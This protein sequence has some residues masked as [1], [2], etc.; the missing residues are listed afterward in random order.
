MASTL[1]RYQTPAIPI[2]VPQYQYQYQNFAE[3]NTNTNT[4]TGLWLK[5]NTNTNTNTGLWLEANTNTNTNT[6]IWLEVNTNTNTN[7]GQNSNTSIPIPILSIDFTKEHL[8]IYA[9]FIKYGK[10]SQIKSLFVKLDAHK[11]PFHKNFV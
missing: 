5:A 7:T 6:L 8:I 9:H 1:G 2:F 11:L 3:V 4:N 10:V